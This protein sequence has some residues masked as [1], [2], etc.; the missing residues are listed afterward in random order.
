MSGVGLTSGEVAERRVE[1]FPLEGATYALDFANDRAWGGTV[2]SLLTTTRATIKTDLMPDSPA[3]YA[4]RTFEVNVPAITPGRGLLIENAATNLF[5]NSGAPVTQAITL[6]TTGFYVLWINGAGSATVSA[7]TA[8]IV[9]VPA[10]NLSGAAGGMVATQGQWIDFYCATAGSVTVTI[11]AAPNAVQL[12][13]TALSVAPTSYV[14]TGGAAATRNADAVVASA[15]LL[16]AIAA[17]SGTMVVRSCASDATPYLGGVVR[18]LSGSPLQRGT[19]MTQGFSLNNQGGAGFH[20]TLGQGTRMRSTREALSWSSTDRRIAANGGSVASGGKMN[21]LTTTSDRLGWADYWRGWIERIDMV[22]SQVSDAKLRAFSSVGDAEIAMWGDSLTARS[23]L[24][25]GRSIPMVLGTLTGRRVMNGGI[26]GENSTQIRTRF[27]ND[28]LFSAETIIMAGRN[29]YASGAAVQADIAAM[30]AALTT[31]RYLVLSIPNAAVASEYVGQ[32]NYDT[33]QALNAALASTYGTRFVD[34]WA[35]MVDAYDPADAMEVQDY[36]NRIVPWR[37]RQPI[38]I[39]A[40]MADISDSATSFATSNL[41]TGIIRLGSE[42][43]NVTARSG[44]TVTAC[45]RGYAGSTPVAHAAGERVETRDSTHWSDA[46]RAFV[47][48]QIANRRTAL[49]W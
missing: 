5:L 23:E 16:A 33:R 27:L 44:N 24:P 43:I 9:A 19:S 8:A 22:P 18:V 25:G 15:T 3:G 46:G 10:D 28:A 32:A 4:F 31:D 13:L 7:G 37:F 12:E 11:A 48:Q 42:Y 17:A 47:A 30:I 39:A 34:A 21:Q 14:P 1:P 40:L 29:N 41:S 49:G 2:A 6:S 20:Y 35:A 36:A 26:D 38:I 45:V